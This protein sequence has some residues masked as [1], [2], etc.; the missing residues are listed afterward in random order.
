M[1]HTHRMYVY[2]T[3]RTCIFHSPI[4]QSLL[5]LPFEGATLYGADIEH[6]CCF[7][8]KANETCLFLGCDQ[9]QNMVVVLSNRH[10]ISKTCMSC[11]IF[12]FGL[13]FWSVIS[14]SIARHMLVRCWKS[15]RFYFPPFGRAKDERT[16]IIWRATCVGSGRPAVY[17]LSAKD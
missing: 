15:G 10:I 9:P 3:I 16:L 14:W 7:A 8:S 5:S 12:S 6:L 11:I 13:D 17:S 2:N 4:S 1:V